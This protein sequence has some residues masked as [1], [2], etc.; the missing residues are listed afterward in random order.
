MWI[1]RLVEPLLRQRAATRPC[2]VLTG[3]RQTGKTSL[4]RRLFPDHAF[5]TL[6]LPSEAEQAELDPGSFLARHPPPLIVDE[7]QYAPGLFR[8]LKTAI[9]ANRSQNGAYLLTGSQPMTLMRSVTESLAG[10][11]AVIELEALSYAEVKAACPDIAVEEFLVRGAFP[12]LY[13]NRDI[14]A[15]GY[16]QSYVA[17]Y[18]ERDLR[19][20]LDVASL[21]DFERFLRATALRSGQLLNQADLARDVGIVGSTAAAW[22]SVLQASHQL[23]LIE[24]WF[25]NATVSLVKRPKLFLRDAGL[26]A[27]LC[28]IHG[29]DELRAS[30]LVGALWETLVCAEMRRLQSSRQGGW[31]FNFWQDRSREADFLAHRGGR[32]HLADAK[33]TERPQA[34]DV[35]SLRKVVKALAPEPVES[36]SIICRAPNVHPLDARANAVPL[37]DLPG[38]FAGE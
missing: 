32:F 26:A 23:V 19:Q 6:D 34:R 14:D 9:D 17:T 1:E 36:L 2:V 12:E 16:L 20:L 33:W 25:S 10:R 21:R 27:F 35:G 37:T 5:V 22:L 7:I 4:M 18:L 13:E 30:P 29:I 3:A 31:Q 28:G 24:P 38:V 11:A 15:R 8:H